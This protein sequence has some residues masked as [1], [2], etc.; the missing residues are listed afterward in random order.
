M[1]TWWI[2]LANAGTANARAS[3]PAAALAVVPDVR[4]AYPVQANGVFT[5]MSRDLASRLLQDWPAQVWSEAPD[6][7]RSDSRCGR[8]GPERLRPRGFT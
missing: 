7:R 2:W 4:M 1:C 5:D 8:G 6:G 3:Q